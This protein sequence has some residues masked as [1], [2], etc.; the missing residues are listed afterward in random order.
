[1]AVRLPIIKGSQL[2]DITVIPSLT[3]VTQ[4][5]ETITF[6]EGGDDLGLVSRRV[7]VF[8]NQ[9]F[10]SNPNPS[11]KFFYAGLR[12]VWVYFYSDAEE[13]LGYVEID[14]QVNS[15]GFAG[16]IIPNIYASYGLQK[17]NQDYNGPLV[18]ITRDS[19]WDEQ[20]FFV[21]TN[22]LD[23]DKDAI[24]NF[25]NH[26]STSS[27]FQELPG[28]VKSPQMAYS[29]CRKVVPS[30]TGPLIRIRRSSDGEETD[31]GFDVNGN[32]DVSDVNTFAGSDDV[33]VPVIYDQSGNNHNFFQTTLNLQGQLDVINLL[34]GRPKLFMNNGY[35]VTNA[36]LTTTKNI[37]YIMTFNF[38]EAPNNNFNLIYNLNYPAN[39]VQNQ[40]RWGSQFIAKGSALSTIPNTV[41]YSSNLIY[42]GDSNNNNTSTYNALTNQEYARARGGV[43]RKSS[44]ISSLNGQMVLNS[45]NVSTLYSSKMDFQELVFYTEEMVNKDLL[46]IKVN[47]DLY[48]DFGYNPLDVINSGV[49]YVECLY[50]QASG[51]GATDTKNQVS[52]FMGDKGIID[53]V[54]VNNKALV[55]SQGV[56]S[57]I[58]M[59]YG[60]QE[61]QKQFLNQETALS[62]GFPTTAGN[63]GL[64][65]GDT[66][67]LIYYRQNNLTYYNNLTQVL[68]SLS[69]INIQFL[70]ILGAR[71]IDGNIVRMNF[72][73][74]Q[75]QT[76]NTILKQ[77]FFSS[78]F[79]ERNNRRW[80][81]KL[82][83]FMIYD[84]ST[85]DTIF[86]EA[87]D[88]LKNNYGVNW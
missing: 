52:G 75:T 74:Q 24:S 36:I 33:F 9:G 39:T 71:I 47:T 38:I 50:N 62:A 85:D 61:V 82:G 87:R 80:V 18:R 83:A 54:G 3:T 60:H 2:L 6:T 20:D 58:Q 66:G 1:M 78:L 25:L 42:I 77:R 55:S 40:L 29:V 56:T 16:D 70:G 46:K 34:G 79:G 48:Y 49:G 51:L 63:T 37:G 86:I 31:I 81:G 19:D 12:K 28:E 72:N 23:V 14:I 57:N 73:N 43:L 26:T 10:S 32:L 22:G 17:N 69:N 21:D 11:I 27:D 13:L 4:N 7:Y 64:Y 88:I 30:Y 65:G 35:Y 15:A 8:D 76:S 59:W 67:S 68:G 84:N 44:N 45:Y 53:L 5:V 41:N